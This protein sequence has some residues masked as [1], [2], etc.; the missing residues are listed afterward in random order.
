MRTFLVFALM[1]LLSQVSNCQNRWV[2]TSGNDSNLG[3]K[4]S[5]YLTINRSLESSFDTLFVVGGTYTTYIDQLS[6]GTSARQIVIT[7]APE[8]LNIT[9]NGNSFILTDDENIF[10]VELNSTYMTIIQD[11]ANPPVKYYN[12]AV[13]TYTNKNDCPVGYSGSR[14]YY[15]V[16]AKLY[17]SLISQV[18]AQNKAKADALRNKQ[19]WANQKGTC[20]K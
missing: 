4:E 7:T 8:K 10:S 14:E 12:T 18:D 9:F 1:T 2:S 15:T 11:W 17:S 19:V 3:T 5:P 13:T 20:I 6:F 16:V